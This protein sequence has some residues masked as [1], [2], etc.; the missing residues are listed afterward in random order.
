MMFTV[1][2]PVFYYILRRKVAGALVIGIM[3]TMNVFFFYTGMLK[4]PLNVNSN[5]IIM[6]N[7][8]YIFYAIGAY[9]ALNYRNFVEK[10]NCRKRNVASII[11]SLLVI[12]Y[13][14]FIVKYG[15]VVISHFFRI[16]YVIAL[17]FVFDFIKEYKIKKW[18]KNSFFLY[19][20][21]LIVLQCIQ[22]ICDIII[23]KIDILQPGFYVLEYIFLPIIV[24]GLLMIV[25]ELLKKHLPNVF[26]ILTG[27]RG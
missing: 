15:N 10:T 5:S 20:S 8:Q 3:L 4:V 16:I 11:L 12:I 17:W 1:V 14:F 2:A 13:F 27:K 26:D 9:G 18:M 22:R 6:L 25:A 23:E 7:Y 24:I 21:H 19:C